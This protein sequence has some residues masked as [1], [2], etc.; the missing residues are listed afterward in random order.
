MLENMIPT[1]LIVCVVL[2]LI[3]LLLRELNCWYWKINEIIKILSRIEAKLSYQA[4][5]ATSM[6]QSSPS[7]S[8]E[9]KQTVKIECPH[10]HKSEEIRTQN[11]KNPDEYSLFKASYSSFLG[12]VSLVCNDCGTKFKM[13]S[14]MF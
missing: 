2:F 12:S 14:Q 8:K 5:T 1:L 3:F 4:V 11:F 6:P 13:E 9:A 10:C 7:L